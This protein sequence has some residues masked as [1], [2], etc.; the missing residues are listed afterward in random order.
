[1]PDRRTVYMTDDGTNTGMWKFIADRKND[2]S[3]G[4]SITAQQ[5]LASS[6]M[7]MSVS[8]WHCFLFLTGVLYLMR[9]VRY[10]LNGSM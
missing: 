8:C 10:A 9:A 2:M 7:K 4:E 5:S 3:S 1:M 6:A